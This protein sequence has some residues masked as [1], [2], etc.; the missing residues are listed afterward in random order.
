MKLIKTLSFVFILLLAPQLY[1]KAQTIEK[2]RINIDL[3]KDGDTDMVV[4]LLNYI[5]IYKHDKDNKFH[6]VHTF[7]SNTYNVGRFNQYNIVDEY[8]EKL[9]G[10]DISSPFSIGYDTNKV[11]YKVMQENLLKDK[12]II[13]DINNDSLLD[14]TIIEEPSLDNFALYTHSIYYQRRDCT[15]PKKPDKIINERRSSWITG[16]YY[17]INMDGIPERI[18]IKYKYFGT[19]LSNTKCIITIFSLDENM[20]KYKN[21]PDIRLVATGQFYEK[22]NFIDINK[23]GYP[24]ILVVDTPSK[25]KSLEEAVSK[26]FNRQVSVSLKFYLYN[27]GA[28]GYPSAPSFVTTT[29]L[30]LLKD[31]DISLNNDYN[32]DG[33]KDLAISQSNHSIIYLFDNKKLEFKETSFK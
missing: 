22:T 15:F 10:R 27:N 29:H 26:I 33:Y 30:D 7:M 1:L 8:Y 2:Y 18:E 3:N 16:I 32:N 31:F 9:L 4:L 14:F 12:F 24:D 25:P 6:L 5:K 23:D 20:D 21:E 13:S 11:R 17:D 19:L 28:K